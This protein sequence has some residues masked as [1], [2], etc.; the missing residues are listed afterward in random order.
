MDE[1][2]FFLMKGGVTRGFIQENPGL[3]D[4]FLKY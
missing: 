3:H 2:I 1:W 4:D